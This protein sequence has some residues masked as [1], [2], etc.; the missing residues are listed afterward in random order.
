MGLSKYPAGLD[1]RTS[2][3]NFT[4]NTDK[5]DY[6]EANDI[7][8]LQ[9]AVIELEKM[10]GVINSTNPDSVTKKLTDLLSSLSALEVGLNEHHHAGEVNKPSQ[11]DL[12]SEVTG[13]LNTDYILFEGEKGLTSANIKTNLL[14]ANDNVLTVEQALEGTFPKTAGAVNEIT[15]NVYLTGN[16]YN[17]FL[18]EW[19]AHHTNITND[20]A[21]AIPD[22]GAWGGYALSNK[23]G[24]TGILAYAN[25]H[26]AHQKPRYGKYVVAVRLRVNTQT[27]TQLGSIVVSNYDCTAKLPTTNTLRDKTNQDLAVVKNIYK[28]HFPNAFYTTIYI[29]YEHIPNSLKMS[30]IYI[31]LNWLDSAGSVFI[32]SITVT[33]MTIAVYED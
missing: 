28:Y 25:T 17:N 29:P 7:N 5:A 10:V 2:N 32:D 24:Q 21:Q 14:D 11:I 4:E 26:T 18:A 9:D 3:L 27:A 22:D 20:K 33:P 23:S 30:R 19:T 12:A 15:G 1:T 8:V 16:F 13:K 31:I 6:V